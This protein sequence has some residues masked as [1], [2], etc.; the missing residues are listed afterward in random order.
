MRSTDIINLRLCQNNLYLLRFSKIKLQEHLT[1]KVNSSIYFLGVKV[2]YFGLFLK[3]Y[4]ILF[5][6]CLTL[7]KKL[8]LKRGDFF[9]CPALNGFIKLFIYPLLFRKSERFNAIFRFR[10]CNLPDFRT[11]RY[12]TR[13]L[14]LP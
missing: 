10:F 2:N 14:A 6:S 12:S 3:I 1:Y 8:N 9:S 7:F 4:P 5:K 13:L 11:C